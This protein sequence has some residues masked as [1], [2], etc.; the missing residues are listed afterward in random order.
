MSEIVVR[1]VTRP[2]DHRAFWRLPYRLYATDPLWVPPLRMEEARRWSPEHNAALR[3]RRVARFLAERAGRVV[4]RI[5][6]VQDDLFA[7]RW[8]P[9]TGFFGFFECEDDAVAARALVGAAA[10]AAAGFG[11][12]RLLGPV[13]L[14]TNDEVGILADGFDTRPTLLSPHN[15]PWYDALLRGA[16]C[17]PERDYHAYSWNPA[18][19]HSPAVERLVRRLAA[20]AAGVTIRT[21]TK[22]RWD[23]DSRTL[24]ELYN[25]SF[26]GLWG[27]TPMSLDEFGEKAAGFK[28]FY[29]P[30]LVIFAEDQG[31]P[32]GFALGLPDVNE[33]LARIDGRLFPFGLLR[34]LRGIPRIRTVRVVLLGVLPAYAGRGVA[35]LLAWQMAASGRRLGVT[36]AELSLVQ[37]SNERVNHVIASMGGTRTKT[38][39]L[40]TRDVRA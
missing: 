3:T 20:G 12:E 11:L 7:R 23:E 4:G 40:F 39:R 21:S 8:A 32:V 25:A 5:A 18:M 10:R 29:R 26:D 27:F 38:Y 19:P 2:A 31:R 37:G 17:A 35:G 36:W 28:P 30:E 9:G 14:T 15:P 1:E 24:F 16:G 33:V 34:L 13:N 6:T 22:A